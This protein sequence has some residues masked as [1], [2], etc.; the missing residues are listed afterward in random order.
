VAPCFE[1]FAD[2]FDGMR[3]ELAYSRCGELC[4]ANS[5]GERLSS[6]GSHRFVGG[7]SRIGI[8]E[9]PH[10]NQTLTGFHG[11]EFWG[12]RSEKE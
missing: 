10:Q 11:Y 1:R 8:I 6:Y 9:R 12:S 3:A 2:A 5:P 7:G 4:S